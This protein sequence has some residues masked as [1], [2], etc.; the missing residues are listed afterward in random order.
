MLADWLAVLAVCL[1]GAMTPG[2]SLV[3]MLRQTSQR[4]A[5]AG[6]TAAWAHAAGVAMYAVAT[7]AGLAVWL[8]RYPATGRAIALLGACYL[9]W[10]GLGALRAAWARAEP[11]DGRAGSR[12]GPAARDG[13]VTAL[14]NPKVAGFFLAL[15]SQF[16]T[17]DAGVGRQL[18]LAS[19]AVGV[20]GSWYSVVVWLAARPRWRRLYQRRAGALDAT[21]GGVLLALAGAGLWRAATGL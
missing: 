13:F 3:V 14:A 7:V 11:A 5:A 9:A 10:L 20:D 18:L 19:T 15:F 16:V 6:L 2:A 8:D 12:L 17:A 4:G 21:S 1:L